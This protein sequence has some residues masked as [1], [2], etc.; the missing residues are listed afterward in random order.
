MMSM[1]KAS[2]AFAR[3]SSGIVRFSSV[4]M[5]PDSFVHLRI[6]RDGVAAR[7]SHPIRQLSVNGAQDVKADPATMDDCGGDEEV[8]FKVGGKEF[9][10]SNALLKQRQPRSVLTRM[11]N[12]CRKQEPSSQIALDSIVD[13]EYFP[14]VLKYIE[15]E[16]VRLPFSKLLAHLVSEMI[17]LKISFNSDKIGY[18]HPPL[19]M[20]PTVH[21]ERLK[22]FKRIMIDDAQ[23]KIDAAT[24]VHAVV[25]QYTKEHERRVK[26]PRG[27][28]WANRLIRRFRDESQFRADC[29]SLLVQF[30]L[31]ATSEYYDSLDLKLIEES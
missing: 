7:P 2:H 19:L 30:D 31:Q 23:R 21:G 1:M 8:I 29:N 10:T 27:D 22:G 18:L 20:A 26:F 25:T 24:L 16:S 4:A 13:V 6:V 11:M 17:T 15:D 3:R 5:M 28:D 12:E 14:F 9:K